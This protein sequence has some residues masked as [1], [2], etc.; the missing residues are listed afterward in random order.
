M[1]SSEVLIDRI[2]TAQG[3]SCGQVWFALRTAPR[4]EKKV[5]E[6]LTNQGGESFLPLC[7]RLSRWKDRR[8]R[9]TAPLSP[10]TR[11]PGSARRN[12][13]A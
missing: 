10:A 13:R 3:L 5:H 12:A 11:L 4:H 1:V 6:R 7:E 9:I 8:M 2:S